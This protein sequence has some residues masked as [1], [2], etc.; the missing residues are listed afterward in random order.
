MTLNEFINKA[1]SGKTRHT[2]SSWATL[3]N[4]KNG[5]NIITVTQRE[6]GQRATMY[7]RRH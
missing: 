4:I 5:G 2:R 6:I 1:T 3:N 7:N